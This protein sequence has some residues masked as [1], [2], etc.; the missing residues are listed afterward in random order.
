MGNAKEAEKATAKNENSRPKH[1]KSK[2][3]KRTKGVVIWLVCILIAVL[4]GISVYANNYSGIYPNTYVLGTKVSDMSESRLSSYLDETYSVD[5]ISGKT[6]LLR[7]DTKTHT[8][9]IDD[10][11][12]SFDNKSLYDA[13]LNSGKD[14]NFFTNTFDFVMRFVKSEV[15][16]PVIA[17]DSQV[18]LSAFDNV[19]DGLETEPVGHTFTIG[20]N[21]V[22]INGPVDGIKA[23]RDKATLD[24][25]KQI[26]TMQFSSIA[27][28]L[29]AVT[30]DPLDLDEFYNWLTSDAEN[31]Y[32]EKID[33]TVK[34]H[35]SKAKAEVDRNAVKS[36]I[37]DLESSESN[38]IE[39]PATTTQPEKTTQQL[40]D[41]LYS[42][43][44]GTYNTSYGGSTAA[45]ANNVKLAA[46]RINGTELMPGEE[47]S[48]DK[49]ILPRTQANGYMSAP[50][51]VGNKV[52]SGLGGGI[53]QPSSTLYVAALY[54]NL[55]I[56]ERHNHSLMVSYMPPGL[57]ATIAEGA[58]DLRFKNSTDYPIKITATAENGIVTFTI[59]GYN[60][61]NIS[62]ELVRSAGGGRYYVTRVV[63]KNGTEIKREEMTSSVYGTKESS[64]PTPETN[65]TEGN[66][67]EQQPSSSTSSE[68]SSSESTPST[69]TPSSSASNDSPGSA[70]SSSGSAS[71][72]SSSSGSASSS[73]SSGSASSSSSGASSAPVAPSAPALAN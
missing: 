67:E 28:P 44:L 54:A 35:P 20:D 2:P 61:D 50:V 55:E 47:F 41:T 64:T 6:I 27:L 21:K 49:T 3:K 1:M 18:L 22:I 56:V 36:A 39:I 65:K 46:S 7:C 14:G 25:E 26:K 33:G 30:P 60:P 9:N 48:Y 62:V 11:K 58:L 69:S 59:L 73:G 66:T 51:Y 10:L 15:I 43:T 16:D 4:I 23:N 13:V 24:V 53:C 42:A 71:S 57:D 70:S 8:L 40:S 72:G 34:V 37:S 38:L 29:E 52:E 68:A 12:V 63:S 17:Y 45:R 32:Y 31:A 19:T 5:K